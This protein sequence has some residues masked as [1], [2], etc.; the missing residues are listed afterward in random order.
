MRS[1]FF[2]ALILTLLSFSKNVVAKEWSTPEAMRAFGE[3]GDTV[4]PA[5]LEK[6]RKYGLNEHP[7]KKKKQKANRNTTV[8]NKTRKDENIAASPKYANSSLA[9]TN[10]HQMNH[11][12]KSSRNQTY[13]YAPA[14][15]TSTPQAAYQPAPTSRPSRYIPQS[16]E[17]A[18]QSWN[19]TVMPGSSGGMVVGGPLNGTVMP[20]SSGGMIVGGP[21]NGTVMPGSSG[22]MV[23]GGPLN[24]TVMPGSDG[25]MIVGG[26]MN[27]TV[28]P[29]SSGGMIIG[30][31][32]NGTYMPPE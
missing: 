12:S 14:G 25:G 13:K 11:S 20:G 29:G 27:G 22:G 7:T 16:T 4:N 1:L 9:N 2:V 26:P 23:V 5:L 10:S 28:M 21:L 31:P 17:P 30:G 18:R 6:H 3:P 32:M 24:G 15:Y 19:G 8:K